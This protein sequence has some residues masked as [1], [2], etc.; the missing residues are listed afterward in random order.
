MILFLK[1]HIS[2]YTKGDGTFVAA[3][4][5]KRPSR[6]TL[7]SGGFVR[8]MHLVHAWRSGALAGAK[9]RDRIKRAGHVDGGKP[10]TLSDADVEH[11][12]ALAESDPA[13]AAKRARDQEQSARAAHEKSP[14]GLAAAQQR[15]E[16]AKRYEAAAAAAAQRAVE[17]ALAGGGTMWRS[18]RRDRVVELARAGLWDAAER[19]A[20]AATLEAVSRLARTKWGFRLRH[21]SAS[22][23]AADSRYLV[24][25]VPGGRRAEVRLSDHF[26]PIYGA[27]AERE[28]AGGA[29]WSDIVIDRSDLMATEDEWRRR[30]LVAAG[31]LDD[32]GGRNP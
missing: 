23:G 1:A 2:A 5:D 9:I 16:A 32:E 26:V 3:H 20:V 22:S 25:D 15:W 7:P 27:R 8:G 10:G 6:I 18:D 4:E 28:M 29:R 30:L 19:E 31:L 13:V 12:A 14:E 11:L 21:T 24:V 17:G